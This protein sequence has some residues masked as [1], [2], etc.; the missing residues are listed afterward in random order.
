[1]ISDSRKTVRKAFAA[2]LETSV[3]LAQKVYDNQIGDFEGQ[4]PVVVVSS[5][6]TLRE[7]FTFQG[8]KPSHYLTINIFVVYSTEHWSEADAEDALD[9]IEKQIAQVISTNQITANWEA[10]SFVDRSTCGAVMV[11][12]TEYRTEAIQ[13]LME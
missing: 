11:G 1:M 2:L 4:S 8:T 7:E 10:I 5:G 3:T 13:I 12:G 6:G 9:D